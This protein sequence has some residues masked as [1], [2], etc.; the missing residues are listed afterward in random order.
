MTNDQTDQP[1]TTTGTPPGSE[2]AGAAANPAGSTPATVE[3]Q[4]A[5]A[6][7]EAAEHYDRYVRAVADHENFRKRS[8]REKD[9]LRQFAAGRVLEDF[10]PVLDSLNLAV[11]AAKQPGAD[12][13][14]LLNGIEMVLTQLKTASGNHGLKEI[15]PL[16]Q[17]FD[18]NQHEAVALQPSPDVPAEHVAGVIRTGYSLNGRLLR[19][20]TVIVSSGAAP[21]GDAGAQA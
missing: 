18:P 11:T 20:A 19:P 1:E 9:E 10:L 14:S 7:K 12:L 6:K 5:A 21:A 2:A 17:K 16:G 13:K 8:L 4:L 15:S 3:D